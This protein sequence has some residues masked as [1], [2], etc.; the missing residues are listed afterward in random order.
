MPAAFRRLGSEDFIRHQVA[1]IQ[2]DD[3]GRL[4]RIWWKMEYTWKHGVQLTSYTTLKTNRPLEVGKVLVDLCTGEKYQVLAIGKAK[5]DDRAFAMFPED[6]VQTWPA[7][8]CKEE[9]LAQLR[10]KAG[11]TFTETCKPFI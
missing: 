8:A 3:A 5:E 7:G 1:M 10:D 4:I 11:Y 6:V 2:V 9:E